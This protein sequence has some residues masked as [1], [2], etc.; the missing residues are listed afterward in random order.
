MTDMFEPGNDNDPRI[1]H[2]AGKTAWRVRREN[3]KRAVSET[4]IITAGLVF[5]IVLGAV[6]IVNIAVASPL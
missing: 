3:R 5:A 2:P 4:G 6:G 1:S